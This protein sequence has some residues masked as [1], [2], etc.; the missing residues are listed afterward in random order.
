V[1]NMLVFLRSPIGRKFM[2]GFTGLCLVLFLVVHLLGNFL[3]FQGSDPFNAY[4][5]LLTSTWLIYP[6]EAGLLVTFL[7][8]ALNGISLTLMNW[9]ARPEQ[10][11]LKRRAGHTSRKSVASSTMIYSGI[12]MGVFVVFHVA[13]MKFGEGIGVIDRDLHAYV[14]RAFSQPLIVVAYAAAMVIL[15]YHLY[16]GLGTLYETFGLAHR[17]TLRRV[18]QALAVALAGAFLA[19]PVLVFT[20]GD[21]L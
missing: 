19:I 16:H 15:G 1:E 10:Y 20:F 8:H 21:K 4:A 6:A 17:R 14:L 3:I 11:Q 13:T 12:V 2:M 7:Y 5:R 9:K 18:L